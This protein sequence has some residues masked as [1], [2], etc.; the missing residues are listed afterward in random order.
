LFA[1][2]HCQL[3]TVGAVTGGIIGSGTTVLDG[4]DH[5]G[6]VTATRGDSVHLGELDDIRDWYLRDI[7][8]QGDHKVGCQGLLE[9]HEQPNKANE[10]LHIF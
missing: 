5:R 6:A 2:L 10:G 9:H 4:A 7:T 1:A 3:Q 8:V